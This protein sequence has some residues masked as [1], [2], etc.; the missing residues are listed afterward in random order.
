MAKVLTPSKALSTNPLKSSAP[1][2]AALAYLGVDGGMPIFHG[3]QGCTAFAL[4]LAVRHFR[5]P[6]PLA[7]DGDGRGRHHPRRRRERRG[8]H[9]QPARTAEAEADRLRLH[10]AHRDARRGHARR[11]QGDQ[12]EAAR[13]GRHRHRLRLDARLRR[14]LRARL[15]QGPGRH[16]RDA[17][18]RVRSGERGS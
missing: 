13:V 8:G 2:G 15:G 7:D 12:G 11:H 10:R 18:S 17:G 9:H 16:D 1:L 3:S 6:I 4:V 14:R 5:E